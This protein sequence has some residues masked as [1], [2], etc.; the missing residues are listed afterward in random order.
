[1]KTRCLALALIFVATSA[2]AQTT[3]DGRIILGETSSGEVY[4]DG[5]TRVGYTLEG[6]ARG[7][8]NGHFSLTLSYQPGNG[9]SGVTNTIVGSN[10]TLDL[11][12]GQSIWGTVD[13][14]SITWSKNG[15]TAGLTATLTITGGSVSS[16]FGSVNGVL[17]QRHGTSRLR[18]TLAL[19][20]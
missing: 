16:G 20:Y 1:M 12:N 13:G 7:D 19:T 10:W 8:L 14:G 2:A 6:T 17:V 9:G 11:P 18:A 15:H 5:R 4:P 3:Y